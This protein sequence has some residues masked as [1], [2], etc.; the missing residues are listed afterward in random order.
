[1][2]AGSATEPQ[3]QGVPPG[4]RPRGRAT[5]HRQK[6]RGRAEV[7]VACGVAGR[8]NPAGGADPEHVGSGPD[9]LAGPFAHLLR[10]V[11]STLRPT[12]GAAKDAT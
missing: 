1:M 5:G 11:H 3:P 10:T 4:P 9:D 2:V 7:R 8:E 12:R 6:R